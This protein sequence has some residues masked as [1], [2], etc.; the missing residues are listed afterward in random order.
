V[1]T[2]VVDPLSDSPDAGDNSDEGDTGREDVGSQKRS[3]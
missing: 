1:I 3:K 2:S